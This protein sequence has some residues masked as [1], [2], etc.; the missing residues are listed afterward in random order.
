MSVAPIYGSSGKHCDVQSPSDTSVFGGYGTGA[1]CLNVFN[2]YPY[3]GAGGY[4]NGFVVFGNTTNGISQPTLTLWDGESAGAGV[5]V[6]TNVNAKGYDATAFGSGG[7]GGVLCLYAS[8]T[9]LTA[10]SGAGKN[11]IVLIYARRLLS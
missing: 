9:T 8:N 7:G 2:F 3:G 10:T 1:E 6:I 4:A 5:S 11:G